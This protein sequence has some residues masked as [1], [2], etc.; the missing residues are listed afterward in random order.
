ME[1]DNLKIN[2]KFFYEKLS[3]KR[4]E[5]FIPSKTLGDE[6]K[7]QRN[8]YRMVKINR[9]IK[10]RNRRIIKW[11]KFESFGRNFNRK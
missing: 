11:S 5:S 3:P 2:V 8:Y 1:E 9:R 4:L 10:I 6:L 7:L